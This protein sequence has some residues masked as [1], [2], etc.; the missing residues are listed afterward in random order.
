LT[1]FFASKKGL[2]ILV[3]AVNGGSTAKCYNALIKARNG[4][5]LLA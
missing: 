2:L 3:F 4:S 5:V 1:W